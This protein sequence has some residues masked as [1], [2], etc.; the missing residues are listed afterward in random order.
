MRTGRFCCI[1]LARA[2]R[3]KRFFF[4]FFFF[5]FFSIL[6]FPTIRQTANHL[7]ILHYRRL[8]FSIVARELS[9]VIAV[10][11]LFPLTASHSQFRTRSGKSGPSEVPFINSVMASRIHSPFCANQARTEELKYRNNE[12]RLGSFVRRPDPP[13]DLSY[14]ARSTKP[15]QVPQLFRF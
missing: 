3:K 13:Q 4:F 15:H 6:L 7:C 14:D 11:R 10:A 8:L 5:F 12:V 1:P 2:A 9:V